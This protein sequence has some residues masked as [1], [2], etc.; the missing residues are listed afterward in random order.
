MYSCK[1]WNSSF[2]CDRTDD[3][4]CFGGTDGRIDSP[5]SYRGSVTSS[6]RSISRSGLREMPTPLVALNRR[7]RAHTEQL[8][9]LCFAR[10]LIMLSISG[11]TVGVFAWPG[12]LSQGWIGIF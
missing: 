9:E 2:N 5:S 11:L 10:P 1:W 6:F 7:L 4:A 8:A 3:R 12:G